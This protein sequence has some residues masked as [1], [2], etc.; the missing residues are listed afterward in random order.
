[1]NIKPNIVLF[2][3]EKSNLDNGTNYANTQKCIRLMSQSDISFLS[4]VG[5]YQFK[6]ENSFLVLMSHIESVQYLCER[7]DQES[8]FVSF[9]DRS[10][11][12]VDAKS[13]TETFL[14]KLVNVS[15]EDALKSGNWTL[16]NETGLYYTTIK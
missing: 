12:L 10:S 15:K 8:Y 7:F 1:M 14:G 11:F 13:Q 16:N 5:S 9:G 3:A 2:S 4:M 6:T